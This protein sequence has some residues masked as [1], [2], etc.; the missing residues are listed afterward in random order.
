MHKV[1]LLLSGILFTLSLATPLPA[2]GQETLVIAD[3]IAGIGLEA[4][5]TGFGMGE[6]LTLTLENPEGIKTAFPINIDT[7]G[8]TNITIA[9]EHTFIAGTYGALLAKTTGKALTHTSVTVLPHHLDTDTSRLTTSHTQI[10]PDGKDAATITVSLRDRYDNPLSGRPVQLI[11]SR[12]SDRI[13]GIESVTGHSGLQTFA[14]STHTPGSFTLR[15]MD[16]LSGQLLDDTI[17]ISAGSIPDGIGN[18]TTSLQGT[19]PLFYAQVSDQSAADH[20]D[21]SA[22][23][24]L[25]VGVE[26]QKVVIRAVDRTGNTVE[27]Y[28]GTVLFSSTDPAATLPAFGQYTFVARDL[29]QREFPLS[30]K[31]QQT[32]DQI[33][34]VE[35][36]QSRNMTGEAT[37]RV[38][39][40]TRIP[41]ERRI[42]ITSHEDGEYINATDILLEGSGPPF[43]NLL[44]TGGIDDARS[45]TDRT[46]FFSTP[47]RLN[48]T[49][50]DFTIRVMDE[51]RDYDSGSIH[52]IL[53]TEAPDIAEISFSPEDPKEE[54][55]VLLV[56]KSE[57]GLEA[58]AVRMEKDS[59]EKF[60]TENPTASGTYQL[61]FAAPEAKAYQPT[62]IAR[63]RAGNVTEIRTTLT[64]TKQGLTRVQNVRATPDINS[65]KLEWDPLEE[66]VDEYRIY[67]G[68]EPENF[69]Y[70][71][72]TGRATTKATVAGLT[73]GRTY[74]FAVTALKDNRESGE[75]SELVEARV[76]G[77][78]LDV[79][80]LD[81]SLLIEWSS[82]TVD[83]PLESFR[84]EY[85]VRPGTYT[86]QRQIHGELRAYTLRDLLNGVTYYL[87]LTPITVTGNVLE[88]LA[89]LGQG[90]PQ[91]LVPGF[92][93]GP[94]DP[95]PADAPL[96]STVHVRT[97]KTPGSGIPPMALWLTGGLT[98]LAALLY[99]HRRRRMQRDILFLH[100]IQSQYTRATDLL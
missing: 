33:F 43:I 55:N 54:T 94:A 85:G 89:A 73:P 82:L 46:G 83:V 32:G 60:L 42:L 62:I 44:V 86:E 77:L 75:K 50:R 30:L 74:Y 69:L 65:V 70:N 91:A 37:I 47:L 10:L 67:V 19:S 72:D 7:E 64:V 35:D 39:G 18:R 45:E 76:K 90:T 22:P 53:D 80:G 57:S 8:K 23:Q 56:V 63:D 38:T 21:I 79:T 11:S 99:L 29:G 40:G 58:V 24:T 36:K 97:P 84:L 81:S 9:G 88:D 52:L 41:D 4:V 31:F 61:L 5:V 28:L 48:P 87:R 6:T 1:R 2:G 3:S 14:V 49:Q 78:T 25:A 15:G 92:R 16:L 51:R 93:P 95:I 96:G 26:A 17:E 98:P 13:E 71:L 27:N 12:P 20:F 100:A 66:E 68:E 34:R 59:E